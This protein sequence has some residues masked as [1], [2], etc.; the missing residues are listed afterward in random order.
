MSLDLQAG[1]HGLYAAGE[2][3]VGNVAPAPD[4]Q[5]DA[6]AWVEVPARI[7]P[8]AVAQGAVESPR[9]TLTNFHGGTFRGGDRKYVFWQI[10]GVRPEG[11]LVDILASKDGGTN[12]E[13]I[14][15]DLGAAEGRWA[16]TIPQV[17]GTAQKVLLEV[18]ARAGAESLSKNQPAV[19]LRRPS[20]AEEEEAAC[21]GR[22]GGGSASPAIKETESLSNSCSG[23]QYSLGRSHLSSASAVR[24]TPPLRISPPS[25]VTRTSSSRRRPR[26][27]SGM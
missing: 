16:W 24:G 1:R 10:A 27:S 3:R 15:S 18:R 11:A 20:G 14:A 19:I 2:D 9:I 13:P 22:R 25:S 12:W 7:P 21:R 6:Q 8:A 26:D 23:S 4:R 5:E 17:P